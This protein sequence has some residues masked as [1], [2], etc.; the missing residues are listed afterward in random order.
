M[1]DTGVRIQP[2]RPTVAV[3]GRADASLAGGLLDLRIHEAADGLSSCEARFGNWGTKDNQVTFLYFDR[4][5]L[6]FGKDIRVSV[7]DH[8]LFDGRISALEGQFPQ[9][10]SPSLV[11]LAEDRY[12]DLRMTRRTRTFADASDADVMRQVASDHGLTGDVE[13]PG[14]THRV[15]AQ[16]NQSDLAF[17]RE[18]ARAIEAELWID[19][20]TL[21]A[22]TRADRGG[23]TVRMGLGNELREFTVVADLAAQRS[24]LKVTGWDVASKQAIAE[25]AAASAVQGELHGG[26]SGAAILTASFA[27]RS[28]SV[29][30]SVPLTSDE[31]RSRAET[32]Y[33]RMAR[34]FVVGR[35]IG[36][37][38]AGLRVGARLTLEH[39]GDLFSGEYY[40]TEVVV[41]FDD[42]LG[43]RTE[44][45]VERASLGGAA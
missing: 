20:S 31:A 32:L 29:V 43:L 35:G 17:V 12:Q 7:G 25:E 28:E 9:G 36:E 40:V 45:T 3:G 27:A 14:P 13:A 41:R 1:T 21:K 4:R 19:G 38:T 44:F 18:R 5:T 37:S 23:T 11:V 6:D 39:L 16:V 30:H 15:V 24:T 22:R 33:K 26:Q 2:A 8:T 42:I 34:R 10:E